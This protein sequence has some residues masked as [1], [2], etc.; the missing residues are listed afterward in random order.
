LAQP[1][2]YGVAPMI[3]TCP[4]CQTRYQ[5]AD[6]AIGDGGR[7][8]QCASCTQSWHATPHSAQEASPPAQLALRRSSPLQSENDQADIVVSAGEEAALDETMLKAGGTKP[9]VAG[10]EAKPGAK[11]DKKSKKGK[12][13]PLK[14]K[15]AQARFIERRSREI[16][17]SMP[18]AR[19]GRIGSAVFLIVALLVMITAVLGRDMAVSTFPDLASLYALAGFKTNVVGLE[20]GDVR[21]I[22][23]L[24]NGNRVLVVGG[25][26]SST[27]D[28]VVPVPPIRVSLIGAD[29]A[30]IYNWRVR[31]DAAELGGRETLRFETQLAAPPRKAVKVRLSFDITGFAGQD[32]TDAMSPVGTN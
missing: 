2:L 15:S 30:E 28:G 6:Q 11:P 26:I 18:M 24:Q 19:L 12:K 32:E 17:D 14:A 1:T 25:R 10:P 27:V 22:S 16:F 23:T 7:S 9:A 8:V 21:T 29:G 5:V 20:L 31:A 13:K 3:I 4:H